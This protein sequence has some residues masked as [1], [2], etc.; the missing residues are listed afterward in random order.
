MN[1]LSKQKGKNVIPDSILKK[2]AT[3]E[4]RSGQKDSDDMPQH[5]MLD[6]VLQLYIVHK[7]DIH[8]IVKLGFDAE[9]TRRIAFMVMRNEFKRQQIPLPL[10]VSTCS[11]GPSWRY[12]I[13]S[14]WRG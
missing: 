8:E 5:E 13:V 3:A 11:F 4:L 9:M 7:K 1:A 14:G 2:P 10:R 12:P 6:K